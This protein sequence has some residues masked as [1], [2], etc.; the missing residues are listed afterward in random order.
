MSETIRYGMIGTGMMGFEHIRNIALLD[1]ARV[2][3]IA[4]PNG[5]SRDFGRKTVGHAVQV[6]DDY[7][8]LIRCDEVDAVVISTP[9]F[10]H[11][12]ILDDVF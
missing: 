10:T 2:T 4:D 9:N 6:F 8:D 12:R 7:R 5:P 1:D 11:A 3:A